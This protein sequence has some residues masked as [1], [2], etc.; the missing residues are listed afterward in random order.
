MA[1][2]NYS[3][4][5]FFEYPALGSSFRLKSIFLRRE[6]HLLQVFSLTTSF[7]QVSLSVF[8]AELAYFLDEI[9]RV[10]YV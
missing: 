7:P 1:I 2:C 10:K 6:N 9:Q 4:L 5:S 3:E 8:A